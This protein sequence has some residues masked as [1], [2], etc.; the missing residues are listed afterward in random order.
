MATASEWF[1]AARWY[2]DQA[3]GNLEEDTIVG[4]IPH[5]EPTNPYLEHPPT[6]EGQEYPAEWFFIDLTGEPPTG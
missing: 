6:Y 4:F 5:G 1:E 2:E 3:G